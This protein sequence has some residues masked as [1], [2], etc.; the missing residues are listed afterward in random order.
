MYLKLSFFIIQVLTLFL[1]NPNISYFA[2]S[3]DPDQLA[4]K[5]PTDLDLQFAIQYVNSYQQSGSSNLTGRNFEK[6]V[7]S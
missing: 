6:G 7:A 5:K 1:L 4:S 3:V 2:N